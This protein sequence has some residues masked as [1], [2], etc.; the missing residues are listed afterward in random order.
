MTTVAYRCDTREMAADTCLTEG[1]ETS[2]MYTGEVDKIFRLNDGSLLGMSG[3]SEAQHICN[4][5][6]DPEIPEH[7]IA[8]ALNEVA[9][10]CSC[11]LVRPDGRM[12]YV[13]T[14]GEG[15]GE[16]TP[17]RD[18]MACVGTGKQFAYGAMEAGASAQR[19]VE[20][21]CKRQAFTKPP[22]QVVQL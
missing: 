4:I 21:S 22:I 2:T 20:I 17:F 11:L 19:A 1:D 15:W 14:N 5:L 6:N 12:I 3:D 16:Y 9:S 10:E 13:S 18:T 8:I 7:E